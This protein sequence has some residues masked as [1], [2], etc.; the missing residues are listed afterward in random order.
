MG[1]SGNITISPSTTRVPVQVEIL[2]DLECEE[3]EMFSFEGFPSVSSRISLLNYLNITI[4]DD[5]CC[6][7]I[8]N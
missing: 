1:I 6:T 2:D 8:K 5:G 7:F 3:K 4:V